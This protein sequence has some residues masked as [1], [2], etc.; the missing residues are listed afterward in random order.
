MP[1][2]TTNQNNSQGFKVYGTNVPYSGMTVEVGGF[3][4][5]TES[6]TFEGTSV[7]LINQPK[8]TNIVT[9]QNVAMNET[10]AQASD[11]VTPFIVGDGSTFGKNTYYYADGNVVPLRTKLHHHTIIPTGRGSNFMTQHQM[12]GNDVDVFT[13]RAQ[14]TTTRTARR[15]AAASAVVQNQ[16]GG[17]MTR[18]GGGGY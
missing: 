13:S 16:S 15:G 12:D 9:D 1:G 2:H 17:G 8:N 10:S 5:T 6:G 18:T 4:Y 3:L 14:T 7:Q 11:V